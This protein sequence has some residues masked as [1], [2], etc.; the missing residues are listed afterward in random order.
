MTATTTK[1]KT[2]SELIKGDK[3]VLVDFYA[4]WC[5]PCKMMAPVLQDLKRRMGDAIHIIKIDTERNPDVA[6]HYQVRGIP[7]LILFK[8]GYNLWQ[9]AGVMQAAQ[10]EQI[11]NQ[12]LEE[13]AEL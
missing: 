13:H 11:I 1:E 7:T 9:Q 4:D 2:F 12:K 3:P 5:G 6:I 10:L 8:K